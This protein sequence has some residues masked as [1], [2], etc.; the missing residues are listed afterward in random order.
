[1]PPNPAVLLS[2][3]SSFRNG[4]R[5]RGVEQILLYAGRSYGT[6]QIHLRYSSPKRGAPVLRVVTF[7]VTVFDPNA[8]TTTTSSTTTT[9]AGSAATVATSPTTFAPTTFAT[10]TT[11]AVT[12]TTIATTTTTTAPPKTT[13]TR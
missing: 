3:G 7:D 13:T 1:M 5:G 4:P 2:I 12:T 8:P 6:T 11:A 9:I 10:T